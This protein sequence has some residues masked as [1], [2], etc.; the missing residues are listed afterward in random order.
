MIFK[1]SIFRTYDIRGLYPQEL[2]EE[3]A[4]Q[5]A[6]GYANLFP[7]LKKIVVAKDVRTSGNEL[8]KRTIQGLVDGGK[9]VYEIEGIVPIPVFSF[10]ICHYKLDGGIMVTASHSPKE[11]NGF[12]LQKKNASPVMPE[13]QEKIKQMIL[14]DKLKK[15]ENVGVV[16]KIN[17]IDAYLNYLWG[18]NLYRIKRPLKIIIDNG[19][20][21][22]G[23]LPEKIFKKLGHEVETL[24]ADFDD[25]FPHHMADPYKAEN[26]ED[27]QKRV[28]ETKADLGFG[29][30][31]D[32]DRL[33]VVD[34]KGR[35]LTGD[36]ILMILARQALAVKKG[37]VI[38]EVRTSQAFIEEVEKLGGHT[39]FTV[40]YHKAVLDKIVETNAVFGGETTGHL[41]FPL[42]YYL[43]DDAIYASLKITQIAAE[44]EDFAKYVDELPRYATSLEI[45]IDYPDETK[46]QAVQRFIDLIKSKGYKFID[47]DGA[48]IIFENGWA[49]VRISNTSPMI[50]AKFEGK[51]KDDLIK[52]EQEVVGLIKEAG[53]ELSEQN[54]REL[55]IM[56]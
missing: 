41:Y 55:G 32:G 28:L 34:K 46:K 51:T 31:G 9:E 15:A 26:L 2:S 1:E 6:L 42:D 19:N 52:I 39:F 33:G 45:F 17:P 50:K 53:I 18:L 29:Y 44:K 10:A 14:G 23:Y 8:I 20:G 3:I 56:H 54:R 7:E 22:C 30:D 43:Y 24:Y 11:W 27:L 16:K 35:I 21:S 48:R 13:E 40:G 5:I 4:Y 12:K 37:P 49:V 38:C 36:E 47:I 25:N